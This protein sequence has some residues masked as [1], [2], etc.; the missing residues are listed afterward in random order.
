MVIMVMRPAQ[1]YC[2]LVADLAP[3][4]ALLGEPQMVCISGA[5]AANQTRL[6]C[7]KLEMRLVAMPT[8]L[9]DRKLALI[10]FGGSGAGLNVGWNWRG[11]FTDRV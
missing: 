8:P 5:S 2:E 7:N 4:C 6:R 1:R 3:H 11:I 10:D 9:A